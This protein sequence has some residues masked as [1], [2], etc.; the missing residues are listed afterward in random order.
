MHV[1]T[2]LTEDFGDGE[3]LFPLKWEAAPDISG[4]HL[5]DITQ[6]IIIGVTEIFT[7]LR[8]SNIKEIYNGQIHRT[9]YAALWCK[10]RQN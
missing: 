8:Q 3:Q 10:K 1:L 4:L 9:P 7:A 6:V 5:T 2:I